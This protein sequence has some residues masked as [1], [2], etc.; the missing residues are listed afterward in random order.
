MQRNTRPQFSTL[1]Y[2]SHISLMFS[3]GLLI[4]CFVLLF[5]CY[6]EIRDRLKK[7]A[8]VFSTL[9]IIRKSLT[10]KVKVKHCDVAI[11]KEVGHVF[12]L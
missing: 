5:I 8:S 10:P 7:F 11:G 2:Y 9:L 6:D 1:S 3:A 4:V 12:D